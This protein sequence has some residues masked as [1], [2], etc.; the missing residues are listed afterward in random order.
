MGA[1]LPSR[2]ERDGLIA[3]AKRRDGPNC[4][5]CNGPFEPQGDLR[6]TLEHLEPRSHGG[7]YDPA[8]IAVAHAVC[9]VMLGDL[10]R[11]EKVRLRR[12]VR[13]A[14]RPPLLPAW[15]RSRKS[16]TASSVGRS[17][18]RVVRQKHNQGTDE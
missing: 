15:H 16:T 10:T 3:N 4:W 9:N 17:A 18:K 2:A 8:N 6:L 13:A 7:T 1:L 11:R 12:S 14:A 5:L